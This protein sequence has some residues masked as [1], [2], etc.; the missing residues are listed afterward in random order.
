MDQARLDGSQ[1]ARL[2]VF[3]ERGCGHFD[4]KA[5]QA[6]RLRGFFGD[7][8][9]MQP[10]RRERPRFQILRGVESRSGSERSQ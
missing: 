9:N 4:L 6:R 3:V 10:V 1:N 7:Y 8:L 2:V 5:S